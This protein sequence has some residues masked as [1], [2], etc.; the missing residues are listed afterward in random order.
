MHYI[1]KGIE[2]GGRV[3]LMGEILKKI[4]MEGAS[5]PWNILF[6]GLVAK[7]TSPVL[8]GA[9]SGGVTSIFS[10]K[11]TL[12]SSVTG[13]A[14]GASFSLISKA[15]NNIKGGISYVL[16]RTKAPNKYIN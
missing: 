9:I 4:G 5:V 11:K 1:V 7:G 8:S 2:E 12:M 15:A 6:T 13:G 16:Q 3:F 10:P 14:S